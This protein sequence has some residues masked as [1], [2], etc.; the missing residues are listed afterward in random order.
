MKRAVTAI[1]GTIAGL[2]ILLGFK[3]G[4]PPTANLASPGNS[5]AGAGA[6]A[7][8]TRTVTG[9]VV[10]TPFGPVQVRVTSHGR[11]ITNVTAVRLPGDTG[12]SQLLSQ[13]AG[14]QLRRE[15]LA[16]QSAH[17]DAVS[18]A[19]YTSD[20]YAQSLQSALDELHA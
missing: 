8:T 1:V 10:Q 6:P 12:Y 16:G 18:G 11:H 14:P 17:I 2:V 4:R 19:T 20:G 15:A 9:P 7:A 13:T 3:T 5:P